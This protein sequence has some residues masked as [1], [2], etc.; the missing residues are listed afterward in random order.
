MLTSRAEDTKLR[1]LDA[2][3]ELFRTRGFEQATMRD[4]AAA[5]QVATGAA[6]Y[7]FDSKEALV[8]A[9]YER[10]ADAMRPLV[11]EAAR[12][13]P[14]LETRLVAVIQAKLD[15]LAPYREML[16]AM[17]RGGADP[18]HPLSPFGTHTAPLRE[19]DFALM[20]SLAR[21]SEVRVPTDLEAHLGP[22]LWMFQMGILFYWL[23]DHS[24]A[25]QQTRRLLEQSARVVVGLLK[26]ASMTIARP[27]RKVVV[28]LIETVR[29][30]VPGPAVTPAE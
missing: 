1:I 27:V 2:A 22:V 11:T 19:A 7:Y 28:D 12:R 5:A 23:I 16:R 24:S 13:A 4:I 10:A 21:D 29:A 20:R 17:L 14:S 15:Y 6:Y 8:L 18:A 26:L 30:G 3:L 9:F 25:Q